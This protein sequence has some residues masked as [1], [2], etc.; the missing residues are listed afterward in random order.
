MKSHGIL[1]ALGALTLVSGL[2][3][4]AMAR[5]HAADTTAYNLIMNWFPE[6]E[7]G[8]YYNAQRLGLYAK[9]GITSKIADFGY[10]VNSVNYLLS[11]QA[12]FAMTN[13]D[14]VLYRRAQGAPIVAILATQQINA[15]GMLWHA[16]DTSIKNLADLSNHTLIFSVGAAYE[17]YLQQKYHYTNIQTRNYQFTPQ[18][19]YANPKAVNQCYVTSEPYTWS[20]NGTK[21]KSE[22]IANSGYNP[23]GDVIVTTESM[24][25]NHPDVV[26]AYVKASIQGWNMYLKDPSATHTY[27]AAAPGSKQWPMKPDEQHYS[28]SQIIKLGLIGGGDAKTHGVGYLNP[29]R[30]TTLQQ[31]LVGVHAKPDVSKLD[32]SKAFTNEFLPPMGSM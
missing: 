11:G 20:K 24:I 26:R 18:A 12:A 2:G 7:E 15:Q 19:F 9:A 30:W 8:G 22:L 3:G 31:Q 28:Y 21:I 6:P 27:M 16:E 17:V 32:V 1:R 4:T 13:A 5:V 29:A 14:D 10:S 23:Y 25:K